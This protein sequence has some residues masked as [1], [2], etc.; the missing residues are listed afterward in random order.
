MLIFLLIMILETVPSGEGL[1]RTMGYADFRCTDGD[2]CSVAHT[3]ADTGGIGVM[4]ALMP[5][6]DLGF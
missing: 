5:P 3:A 2:L 4:S 1:I 6:F